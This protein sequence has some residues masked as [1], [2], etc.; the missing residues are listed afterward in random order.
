MPI[1]NMGKISLLN[2][3]VCG[4]LTMLFLTNEESSIILK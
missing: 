4:H 2:T 3:E 1:S